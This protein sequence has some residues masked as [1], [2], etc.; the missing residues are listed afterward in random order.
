MKRFLTLVILVLFV[1]LSVFSF[2]KESIGIQALFD[3][4]QNTIP[5]YIEE[6]TESEKLTLKDVLNSYLVT[7]EPSKVM[8]EKEITIALGDESSKVVEENW[9][10]EET[11]EIVIEKTPYYPQPKEDIF[12]E[13]SVPLA[14]VNEELSPYFITT[15]DYD[16]CNFL[17]SVY[18]DH[19]SLLFSSELGNAFDELLIYYI[20]YYID[21]Y[22]VDYSLDGNTITVYYPKQSE[23]VLEIIKD[24]VDSYDFSTLDLED[25]VADAI[26]EDKKVEENVVKEEPVVIEEVTKEESPYFTKYYVVLGYNLELAVYG[27]HGVIT[28]DPVVMKS[29]VDYVASALARA[30][31][32]FMRVKYTYEKGVMTLFYPEQT[33]E[34][35]RELVSM[36]END[37]S[38]YF[39]A[40]E[41]K[42]KVEEKI[43]IAKST[44]KSAEVVADVPIIEPVVAKS[45]VTAQKTVAEPV[46]SSTPKSS[47]SFDKMSIYGMAYFSEYPTLKLGV[48]YDFT[49]K[50][51][52]RLNIFNGFEAQIISRTLIDSEY[53]IS[54]YYGAGLGYSSDIKFNAQAFVGMKRCFYDT[55]EISVELGLSNLIFHGTVACG[56]RF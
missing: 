25:S 15:L 8:E 16:G 36:L 56:I 40:T 22:G 17:V 11:E 6:E 24:T 10:I 14:E 54:F 34:T 55:F 5:I 23:E 21:L 49:D 3:N 33:E 46:T 27:D 52:A 53:D 30:Y 41:Q 19:A 38:F 28:S 18:N 31:P 12:E 44:S 48:S 4:Y 13:E 2:S 35:L 39:S 37:L 51:T 9:E 50:I 32:D 43:N 42:S 29:D 7:I 26:V 1:S 20:S 45:S 47:F